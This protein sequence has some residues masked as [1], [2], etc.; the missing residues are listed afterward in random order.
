MTR[1]RLQRKGRIRPSL[2]PSQMRS[3]DR[4]GFSFA[5]QCNGGQTGPDTGIVV[6]PAVFNGDVKVNPQKKH[7]A[8]QIKVP[9]GE[10][11]HS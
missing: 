2:G 10:F 4:S 5:R 7:L 1:D 9:N 8:F 3:K 6:D 11:G